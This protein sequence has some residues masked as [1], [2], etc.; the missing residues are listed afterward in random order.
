DF[1]V[2]VML[3]QNLFLVDIVKENVGIVLKLDS[4]EDG[5]I[6]KLEGDCTRIWIGWLLLRRHSLHGLAG[7]SE[8]NEP[9]AKAC[10]GQ[11]EPILSSTYHGIVPP[12]VAIVE[13]VLSRIRKPVKL[14]NITHLSQLRKDGHPSIYVVS[15]PT[16]LDCTHWCVTG[17]PDTWN[18]ILYNTIL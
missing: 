3:Q 9:R 6:F 1:G 14:P 8:W 17:V 10:L 4:I 7:G 11:K 18:Q 16:G 15:S 2:K 5:I 12:A 13:R